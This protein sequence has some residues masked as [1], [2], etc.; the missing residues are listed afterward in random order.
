M[1][2][3][4]QLRSVMAVNVRRAL[5]SQ[6][7]RGG[8]STVAQQLVAHLTLVAHG[9]QEPE[10]EETLLRDHL[11]N[12]RRDKLRRADRYADHDHATQ[13]RRGVH[14]NEGP[15]EVRGPPP[16]RRSLERRHR[17]HVAQQGAVLGLHVGRSIVEVVLQMMI[18]RKLDVE[19]YNLSDAGPITSPTAAA[20]AH[21]GTDDYANAKTQTPATAA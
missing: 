2:R 5:T 14:A 19:Q 4:A 9:A 11:G 7:D 15:K 12:A 10:A 13:R 17:E 18:R 16:L 20:D 1:Q 6:V 3:L 8:N 21:D